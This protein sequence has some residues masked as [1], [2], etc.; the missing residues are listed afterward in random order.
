MQRYIH[1]EQ[2]CR[3]VM[4]FTAPTLSRRI[5]CCSRSTAHAAANQS[6]AYARRFILIYKF[7]PVAS[8]IN[9]NKPHTGNRYSCTRTTFVAVRVPVLVVPSVHLCARTST[10]SSPAACTVSCALCAQ[11]LVLNEFMGYLF[12]RG[13]ARAQLL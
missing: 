8:L 2:S 4:Q 13:G 11:F 7:P 6:Q 10:P 9:I 12:V 1:A 3:A 5:F